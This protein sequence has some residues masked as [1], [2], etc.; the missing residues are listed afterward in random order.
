MVIISIIVAPSL[1]CYVAAIV[2][3]TWRWLLAFALVG[4]GWLTKIWIDQSIVSTTPGYKEGPGGGL[5]IGLLVFL[6]IGFVAGVSVRALTLF[7][8][9]KRVSFHYRLAICIVGLPAV[10]AIITMLDIWRAG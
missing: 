7:L 1:V 4:G 8:R 9:T 5:G 2:L 3:P 10:F 6:T